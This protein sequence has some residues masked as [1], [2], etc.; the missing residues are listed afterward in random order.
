MILWEEEVQFFA[1]FS[2]DFSFVLQYQHMLWFAGL[3]GAMAFALA[4]KS[5]V[6]EVRQMFFT[7]TCVIT[8]ATVIINGGMTVPV[9]SF[10]EVR[11]LVLY[12]FNF[13]NSIF[14][15]Q[16]SGGSATR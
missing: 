6:T 15:F 14:F 16:D 10:L 3:R 1:F 13:Q 9:L 12:A 11:I 5:P 8:I 4:L 7:T 2:L